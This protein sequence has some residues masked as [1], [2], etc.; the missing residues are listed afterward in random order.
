MV[1]LVVIVIVEHL[2][3]KKNI[4][5]F[6]FIYFTTIYIEGLVCFAMSIIVL[7]NY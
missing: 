6:I 7:E 3:S 1:L 2:F 5:F 4:T